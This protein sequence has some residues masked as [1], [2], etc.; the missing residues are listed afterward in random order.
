[1]RKIFSVTIIMI[2]ISYIHVCANPVSFRFSAGTIENGE[3]RSHMEENI[4]SLLSEITIAA[5]ENSPLNLTKA[6]IEDEAKHRLNMLWNEN[7]RFKCDKESNISKCL[8]DFQGFQVRNI[9]ITILPSDSSYNGSLNRELTISLNKEGVITG[10]RLSLESYED[11]T[12]IM[13]SPGDVTDT[14]LRREI[15][16][17]LEDY[18]SFYSE[19]NIEALNKIYCDDDALIITGS[20]VT[21]SNNDENENIYYPQDNKVEYK[22]SSRTEYISNLAKAFSKREKGKLSIDHISLM[23]HGAVQNIYGLTFHQKLEAGEFSDEGW[24]FFMWDFSEPGTPVIRVR[25]WQPEQVVKRDGVISL[26]CI[27]IP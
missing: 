9:P 7:I 12:K 21:S 18:V 15:L 23:M 25:T 19:R 2:C 22:L 20:L 13:F 24:A 5:S 8:N 11:V 10:V 27:F 14:R 4:S 6:E 26:D 3:L 16:K 17:W 1:M